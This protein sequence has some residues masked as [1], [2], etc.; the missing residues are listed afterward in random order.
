MAEEYIPNI[1]KIA[2]TNEDIINLDNTAILKVNDDIIFL[3][4][5]GNPELSKIIEVNEI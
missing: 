1:Y 3:D 5:N 2:T 4:K